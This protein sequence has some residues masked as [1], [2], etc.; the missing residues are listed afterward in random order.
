MWISISRT[1]KT[2]DLVHNMR[3]AIVMC[4]VITE[5]G[6]TDWVACCQR[7]FVSP[8]HG[9]GIRSRAAEVRAVCPEHTAPKPV[10][11]AS[12]M[13]VKHFPTA[14]SERGGVVGGKAEAQECE[15]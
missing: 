7:V 11:T 12:H 3:D 9:V 6:L 5:R 8:K 10:P 15:P 4:T 13:Y 2:V 14:P 1:M